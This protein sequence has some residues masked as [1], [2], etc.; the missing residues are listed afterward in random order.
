MAWVVGFAR[1]PHLMEEGKKTG[2]RTTGRHSNLFVTLP[3]LV[4]WD[5]SRIGSHP[6]GNNNPFHESPLNSKVSGL[7]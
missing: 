4:G 1:Q 3:A 6:L 2:E 7:P 5:W